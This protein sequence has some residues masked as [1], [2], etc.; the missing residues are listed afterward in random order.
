MVVAREPFAQ[1]EA[2]FEEATKHDKVNGANLM[3]LAT[4][5]ADGLPSARMVTLNKYGPE[6]F[7]FFTNYGSRKA[8]EL[9]TNSG[10]ALVFYW[11]PL[12][13]QIRVE[14]EVGRLPDQVEE[15]ELERR[16]ADWGG[17]RVEPSSIEFYQGHIIRPSDRL[18]FRRA[19][20]GE[21]LKEVSVKVKG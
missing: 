19:F 5:S 16:G 18:R 6:G 17:Y 13:R 15:E 21:R 4:A 3:C 8:I 7:T 11:E 14:G 10:A 1:F 9:D 20:D 12:N 2:W